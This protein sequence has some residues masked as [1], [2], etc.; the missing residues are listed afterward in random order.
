MD[1]AL[2]V[3]KILKI[4][5]GVAFVGVLIV[6]VLRY[7]NS[8]RVIVTSTVPHNTITLVRL[9]DASDPK[10][11]PATAHDKLSKSVISGTYIITVG[12][13]S[14]QTNQLV[15][16]SGRKTSSYH[17]NPAQAIAVEPLPANGSTTKSP[18]LLL[19]RR[20]LLINGNG[21]CVG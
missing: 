16:V 10:V 3:R 1:S 21:F 19:A 2:N 5:A 6:L 13:N 14:N 9:E 17:I 8:G 11:K 15:K 18:L 7:L 20:S 12:A 4:V